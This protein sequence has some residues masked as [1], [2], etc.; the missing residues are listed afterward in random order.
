MPLVAPQQ[1]ACVV[2]REDAGIVFGAAAVVALVVA[3]AA[4]ALLAARF[5]E[6]PVES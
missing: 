4:V 3:A 6:W 1:S 5:V 2:G